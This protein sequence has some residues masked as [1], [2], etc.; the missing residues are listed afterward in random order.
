[1][2]SIYVDSKLSD[3]ERRQA[4]YEGHLFVH[5]A[6]PSSTALIEH[7]RELIEEAFGDLDPTTA[8]YEL[9]VEEF[10]KI[11]ADLKPRFIHHPTSKEHVKGVLTDLGADPEK[12]YF[13][14]PKMRTSTSDDYL[15]AGIS[16]AFHPHRDTWYSAPMQQLNWW[17]PIYPVVPEN[18]MAF[19]TPYFD[20]AVENGS[21]DFNYYRW[22][23]KQRGD[24]AKHVKKDT[25]KQPKPEQEIELDP[26]IRVVPQPGEVLIFSAAHLHSTVPNTSGR[27]RF[28]IDFRTVNL[29]DLEA[30]RGARNVDSECTGTTMREYLRVT[31]LEHVPDEVVEMYDDET[32]KDAEGDLVFQAQG[33]G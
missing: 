32:A 29:D 33:Q 1:M 14:V 24:T 17:L 20:E 18:V 8:Q 7:A 21:R 9:P 12:T 15:T 2:N 5:S 10:A 4:L 31:D 28:S 6:T 3:D 22:N 13:E 11:L 26:Q 19:H 25:R 16:Y 23:A 27:T 30:R